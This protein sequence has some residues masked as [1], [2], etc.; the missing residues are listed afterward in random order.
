MP[1]TENWVRLD[2]KNRIVFARRKGQ[3]SVVI[4]KIP[5]V[6]VKKI[7]VIGYDYSVGSSKKYTHWQNYTNFKDAMESAKKRMTQF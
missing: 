4:N 6:N 5:R 1:K 7:K 2:Y 3:G